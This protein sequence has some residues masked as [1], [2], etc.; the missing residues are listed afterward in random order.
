MFGRADLF[1]PN[2]FGRADLFTPNMFGRADFRTKRATTA[3]HPNGG[4]AP[5]H[6]CTARARR[7]IVPGNFCIP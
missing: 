6:A 5:R 1:T 3:D 7:Q 4:N 2:M